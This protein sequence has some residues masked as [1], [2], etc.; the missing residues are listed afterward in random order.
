MISASRPER[1]SRKFESCSSFMA[2]PFEECSVGVARCG[3]RMATLY[4][5][6]LRDA[7]LKGDLMRSLGRDPRPEVSVVP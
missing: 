4:Q 5:K 3:L 2:T 1:L 6:R 7:R